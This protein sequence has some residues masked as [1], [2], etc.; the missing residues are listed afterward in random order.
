MVQSNS[1]STVSNMVQLFKKEIYKIRIQNKVCKNCLLGSTCTIDLPFQVESDM[2]NC[3]PNWDRTTGSIN[4]YI[5]FKK[6]CKLNEVYQDNKMVVRITSSLA[7]DKEFE[8][9]TKF[10]EYK[11]R[12]L[13]TAGN[14]SIHSQSDSEEARYGGFS[15][16]SKNHYAVSGTSSNKRRKNY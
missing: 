2:V 12:N 9:S 3:E 11:S 1:G 15:G 10:T 14:S 16:T 6:Q 4:L 7:E 5:V 13:C 8:Y